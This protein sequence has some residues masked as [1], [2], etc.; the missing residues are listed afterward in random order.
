MPMEE[1][2][3]NE[4]NMRMENREKLSLSGVV[5]VE[6]F[7]EDSMIIETTMG[8]VMLSG[9]GMHILKYNV[10][11]GELVIEGGID[12][13]EYTDAGNSKKGLFAKLFG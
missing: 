3:T 4:H 12:A 7:D 11:G 8:T 13:F 6:S 5:D 2:R 9:S 1:K 10:D